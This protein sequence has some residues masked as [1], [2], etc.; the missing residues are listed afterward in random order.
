MMRSR[1]RFK[2]KLPAEIFYIWQLALPRCRPHRALHERKPI[3][4]GRCASSSALP[5][6]GRPTSSHD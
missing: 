1:G 5:L 6:A 4:R 2:M 3:R